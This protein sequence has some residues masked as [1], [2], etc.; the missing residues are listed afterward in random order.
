MTR[1]IPQLA[2]DFVA[3]H[4]AL[5]LNPY[6]DQGGYPTVGYGHLLTKDVSVPL[7]RYKPITLAEAKAYL[8][9]DLAVAAQAVD[10]AVAAELSDNA[11][12]A[13]ISLAFNIGGAAFASSTVCK[14]IGQGDMAGAAKAFGLWNK[15]RDPETGKLVVSE[16]LTKRRAAE[17]ELFLREV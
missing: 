13:C 10:K 15:V 5:R 16:G 3:Q 14:R 6:R 11:F 8:A 1:P 12:A 2:V 17:A 7:T 4:E 9:A